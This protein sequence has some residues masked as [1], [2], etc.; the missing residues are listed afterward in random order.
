MPEK[1]GWS[2][3]GIRV[4][5]YLRGAWLGSGLQSRNLHRNSGGLGV[6]DPTNGD[7]I[8]LDGSPDSAAELM[9]FHFGSAVRLLKV[10]FSYIG[11]NDDFDFSV[12]NVDVAL[13]SSQQDLGNLKNGVFVVPATLTFNASGSPTG[14]AVGTDFAFY[15]NGTN[16]DYKMEWIVVDN[17]VVPEP[18]T[19]AIWSL[20]STIGFGYGWRKRRQRKAYA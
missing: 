7:S 17:E 13:S 3:S 10:G 2:F 4:R 14:P 9:N 11:G 8:Q 16:D 6:Y 15:T 18:A 5:N 20:F 1:I 12:N 19:L